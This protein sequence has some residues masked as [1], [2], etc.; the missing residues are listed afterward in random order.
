MLKIL[1]IVPIVALVVAGGLGYWHYTQM[2]EE[3]DNAL[4]RIGLLHTANVVQE[5]TIEALTE[6]VDNWHAQSDLFRIALDK[7]AENQKESTEEQR[8]LNDIL[9]KHDLETLSESKPGLI[10]NRIN[11]GSRNILEDF[12]SVTGG[13]QE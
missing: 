7:M 5:S 13:L 2:K 10:E 3:R 4:T 11:V 6:V 8:R 9:G 1:K 12:E